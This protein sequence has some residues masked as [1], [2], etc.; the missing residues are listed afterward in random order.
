MKEKILIVDDHKENIKLL[1]SILR[2]AGY[3]IGFAT[4]GMQAIKVVNANNDFKLILMDIK[5][6]VLNGLDACKKIKQ[7]PATKDIPVIFLTAKNEKKDIIEGFNAGGADYITKPFHALELLSRVKTHIQLKSKTDEL[8]KTAESLKQS[9]ATKDK[10][11]SIIS[12][13][14]RN[15]VSVLTATQ[16]MMEA[17]VNKSGNEKLSDHLTCMSF[18]SDTK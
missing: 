9:N 12:H 15:P 13:D 11:F 7:N 6:P 16:N 10:F 8:L 4:D 1:G 3:E 17:E 14:L 2:E 5:M 18:L